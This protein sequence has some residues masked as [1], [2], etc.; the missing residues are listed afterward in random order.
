MELSVQTLR[1]AIPLG[2]LPNTTLSAHCAFR[3]PEAT[4]NLIE[5][6]LKDCQRIWKH[7]LS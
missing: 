4:E 3:T 5:A 6:A 7:G 2:G 1:P